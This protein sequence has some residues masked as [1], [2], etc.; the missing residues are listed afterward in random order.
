MAF[1]ASHVEESSK[2][3]ETVLRRPM[4]IELKPTERRYVT[5][6]PPKVRTV[7]YSNDKEN[8]GKKAGCW[9]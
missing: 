8:E 6:W 7:R 4:K 3:V 5:I 1:G 2:T 9:I